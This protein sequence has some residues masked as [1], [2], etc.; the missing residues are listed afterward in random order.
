MSSR[1]S[2]PG[3]GELF[4][5]FGDTLAS[6]IKGISADVKRR[7]NSPTPGDILEEHHWFIHPPKPSNLNTKNGLTD[8]NISVFSYVD[9]SPSKW[10]SL[11]SFHKLYFEEKNSVL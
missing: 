3:V 11:F 6:I 2:P 9:L 7:D 5:R 1:I 10:T 8:Q 4:R